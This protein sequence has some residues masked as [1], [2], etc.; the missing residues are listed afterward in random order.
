MSEQYLALF[1]NDDSGTDM[2]T[3][4]LRNAQVLLTMGEEIK[5]GGVFV[6]DNVIEDVGHSD[7][8]PSEAD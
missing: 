2:T 6:R 3:L 4:L 7:Q 1:C 8:M 5:D